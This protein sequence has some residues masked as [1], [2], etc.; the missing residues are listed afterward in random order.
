MIVNH[1]IREALKLA[2]ECKRAAFEAAVG[3][4]RCEG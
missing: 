1:G 3:W 2:D 4:R